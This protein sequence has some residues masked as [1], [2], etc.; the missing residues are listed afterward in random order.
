LYADN[1][2]GIELG[3]ENCESIFIARKNIG[4]LEIDDIKQK[5]VRVASNSIKNYQVAKSVQLELHADAN[6]LQTDSFGMN[7]HLPF[8]RIM[9]FNDITD[10]SIHYADGNK[11][12]FVVDYNE[13]ENE[14]KLGADNIHQKA[15]MNQFGDLFIVIGEKLDIDEEFPDEVI[16]NEDER[17]FMWNMFDGE[18]ETENG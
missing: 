10:I 6:T 12:Y 11:E 17:N 9:T 15:K 1:I 16:N 7:E 14:G 2:I 5:I 13:G 4:Y 8:E 3:H 18:G